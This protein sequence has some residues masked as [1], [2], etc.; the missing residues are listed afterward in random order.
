MTITHENIK[1][2]SY[3]IIQRRDSESGTMREQVV[4]IDSFINSEEHTKLYSYYYGVFGFHEG[5]CRIDEIRELTAS[6]SREHVA[7]NYWKL[8]QQF[9]QSFPQ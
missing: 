7:G 1:I 8:P 4:K 3:Y 9:Y 6:E 2:D 5:L